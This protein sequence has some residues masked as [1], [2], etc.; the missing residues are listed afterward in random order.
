MMSFIHNENETRIQSVSCVNKLARWMV[1]HDSSILQIGS[2]N[3]YNGY[4]KLKFTFWFWGD[5]QTMC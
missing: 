1:A 2:T 4:P 3:I 5:R